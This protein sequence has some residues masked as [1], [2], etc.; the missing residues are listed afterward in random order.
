M[1]VRVARL[2]IG[3]HLQLQSV[4]SRLSVRTGAALPHQGR[5][6]QADRKPT[7]AP[8][9]DLQGAR[10]EGEGMETTETESLSSTGTPLPSLEQLLTSADIKH[11]T[12]LTLT[13]LNLNI[14]SAYV[15][16]HVD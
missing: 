9:M 3:P 2:R 7:D 6:S 16:V 13:V 1:P 14:K 11:G 8:P 15:C 10:E 5:K 4:F 12:I